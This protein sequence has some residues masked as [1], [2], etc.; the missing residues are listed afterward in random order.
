[1]RVVEQ[2]QVVH[3]SEHE[4]E[5]RFRVAAPAEHLVEDTGVQEAGQE[6]AVGKLSQLF[7]VAPVLV[8]EPADQDAAGGVGDE[9]DRRRKR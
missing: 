2:L 8:R 5:R 7:E 6:V 4:Q 9:A 1:M 3:V